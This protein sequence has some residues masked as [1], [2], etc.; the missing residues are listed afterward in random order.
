MTVFWIVEDG[1]KGE[2]KDFNLF[3]NEFDERLNSIAF[4]GYSDVEVKEF[5]LSPEFTTNGILK[6]GWRF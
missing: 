3:E 5:I 6:K 4:T 2:F 1:F